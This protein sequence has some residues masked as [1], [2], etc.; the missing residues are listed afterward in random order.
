MHFQFSCQSCEIAVDLQAVN[1]ELTLCITS[2]LSVK[3]MH[4][5]T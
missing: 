1:I 4:M 2:Y 5:H 3:R